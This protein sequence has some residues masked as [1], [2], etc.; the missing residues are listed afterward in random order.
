M[1]VWRSVR[2][3][4]DTKTR[5]SRRSLALPRRCV[6]ALRAHQVKQDY[7]RTLARE[8]WQETGLVFSSAVGIELNAASRCSP[9]AASRS[10]RS[11]A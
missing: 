5:K 11:R 4:G 6:E 2:E 3:Y 10:S 7:R 8:R 1:M 9:T